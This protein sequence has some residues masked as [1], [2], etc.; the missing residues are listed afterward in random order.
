MIEHASAANFWWAMCQTTHRDCPPNAAIG[1]N[2]SYTFDMSLKGLLQLLSGHRLVIIPQLIRASGAQFIEFA[3]QHAIAAFDCT[4]SQLT[5]LI[6]AGLMEQPDYRPVSVLIGGE[7]IGE[8]MWQSL[9]NAEG[10]RYYNMYGPTE[11]TVDATIGLIDRAAEVAHIGRP[12]ANMQIYIL[13]R[14]G[15][16]VPLGVAGEIHIGGV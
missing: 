14:H 5:M 7:A 8:S 16:P 3:K 15:A 12:I 6:E 13:D 11:C 2:A 10:I 4:P 1:W 9:C